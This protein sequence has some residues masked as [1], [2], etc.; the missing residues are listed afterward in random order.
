MYWHAQFFGDENEMIY[1]CGIE[2]LFWEEVILIKNSFLHTHLNAI[3]WISVQ[4][5]T[6][7]QQKNF[8]LHIL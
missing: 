7:S 8:H 3:R 1:S 4:K 5:R 2:S 6:L